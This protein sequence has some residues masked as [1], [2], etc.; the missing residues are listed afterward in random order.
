MTIELFENRQEHYYIIKDG[1]AVMKMSEKEF[2][3]LKKDGR[4]P[5]LRKLWDAA[6]KEREE[7][8]PNDQ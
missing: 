4:S 7:K 6:K 3:E 8:N 2:M 1:D 5:L